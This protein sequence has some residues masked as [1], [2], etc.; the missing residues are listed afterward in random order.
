[1]SGFLSVLVSYGA[2]A[3]NAA[4]QK[5]IASDTTS[6]AGA[7]FASAV[8][9]SGDG[10][11]VVIGSSLAGPADDGAVYVYYNNNGNWVEQ[12]KLV[13]SNAVTGDGF[14]CAVDITKTGDRIIVGAQNAAAIYIFQ[15][16]GTVW[17]EELN[18]S[19]GSTSTYFG[20]SVAINDD[21]TVI[22]VG[23]YGATG[24]VGIIHTYEIPG[25]TWAGLD[26]S[27]DTQDLPTSATEANSYHGWAVACN[28]NGGRC[29]EGAPSD[30][31]QGKTNSGAVT[32]H[33]RTLGVPGWHLIPYKGGSWSTF[34]R[35][36]AIW[37]GPNKANVTYSFSYDINILSDGD[38]TFAYAADD[39]ITWD[40]D[41]G[42]STVY[43]GFGSPPTKLINLT[44]GNHTLNV[45]IYNGS[46]TASSDYSQNPGGGA[47]TVTDSVGTVIWSTLDLVTTPWTK[48]TLLEPPY[49]STDG[50]FGY[51]VA[52]NSVG[53]RAVIGAIGESP[54]G[55]TNAGSA[56][57]YKRTGTVW[58][59]EQQLTANDKAADDKFGYSV[60]INSI[61]DKVAIGTINADIPTKNNTGA[62]YVFDRGGTVWTQSEKLTAYD[63]AVG[64]NL[65]N[66][67]SLN[68]AGTGVIVGSLNNDPKAS[69]DSGAAYY[70][71]LTASAPF[72]PA[73]PHWDKVSLLIIADNGSQGDKS[74]IDMSKNRVPL[75]A[76]SAVAINTTQYKFGTGSM[77]FPTSGY[78]VT[79]VSTVFDFT[80]ASFTME[81]WIYPT[82][83]DSPHSCVIMNANPI[84]G[85]AWE[86]ELED[87]SRRLTFLY[88]YVVGGG[89]SALSG[90][91]ITK[92]EWSHVAVTYDGT[93]IRLYSNGV[94]GASTTNTLNMGTG[95]VRVGWHSDASFLGY[96]DEVR[97][98][99]GVARYTDPTYTIPTASFYS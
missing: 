59:L 72:K 34:M 55:I 8:A 58:A 62:V 53:D 29:I 37:Y 47:M 75:T 89:G 83:F 94:L 30:D 52:M 45:S 51:S 98:T 85:K 19:S 4:Y 18:L 24:S 23:E 60:S 73:D 80:N 15:R 68:D 11:Y 76:G 17:T 33:N 3:V 48:D 44:A 56:Y 84:S 79:P 97:I 21:G 12:A 86:L 39:R 57:I 36:Y 77:A 13:V 31:N 65:G 81:A 2:T 96:M 50:Q 43:S 54:D 27:A 26:W 88:N 7:N 32:I 42:V 16:S 22:F 95:S 46:A 93:T 9:L 20:N 49:A 64:D 63:A 61:G 87:T 90:P 28:Y 74:F 92:N 38:Y 78:V 91:V 70:F 1:M 69:T 5:I 71:A 6:Q 35:T 41:G 66:A 82:G 67:I 10:N 25:S 99:K 40:V 14:G